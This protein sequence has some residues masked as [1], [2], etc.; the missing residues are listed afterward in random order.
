MPVV[1]QRDL[2][3][4]QNRELS[5]LKFNE[6]VLA[7]A[8][9][10][11]LPLM[12]RLRFVSIFTSNLDEFFMVRVGSLIDMD[13]LTPEEKENKS[14][15]TPKQQVSAI[16]T[17]VVPLIQRRDDIYRT[18][19]NELDN[20]GVTEASYD[21][22]TAAQKVYVQDYYKENIRPLLSPQVIDRSHPFPHLKNKALYAAALLTLSGKTQ[23]KQAGGKQVAAGKQ[24][25]GKQ[26]AVSKHESTGKQSAVLGIVD[27]PPSLPRVIM[28]PG[29]GVR[30]IRTEVVIAA[31]MKKIFKIYDVGEQA[32]ISITRNADISLS[33]EHYDD[34]NPDLLNYMRSLLKKRDR[35]APVRLE[36]EGKAPRLAKRL[37]EFLKLD[38][39]RV[40]SCECP[41][42]IDYVDHIERTPRALFNAPH[43]PVYPDYL[44]AD[45]SVWE[46]IVQ[47]DVLLFYP[48]QSMQP[49]LDLLRQS[50]KDPNVVSIKITIYRL[51]RNSA[52]AKALCA[53]AEN[54]K[55]VTV[56]M[57]LRARFDEQNNIDWSMELEEAGCR[58]IYGP[59]NLKCHAKL[60]LI[61][62]RERGGLGYIAQIG[63][64]NYNEKTSTLYTDFCMMTADPVITRDAVNFFENM[65]IGNSAGE[66]EK[67]LVAPFAMKNRIMEMIDGQ[68][69]RG[70]E[71][72]IRV[73]AN[74][75]TD[76]ELI[77]KLSEA[78]CAGVKVDLVIRGI[79]CLT[80][81]VPGKTENITVT[82][83]VGRFLEH[84]RIYAFGE[85]P[86]M[87]LYL[88][89]ADFMTRNQDR[90][91]EVGAPV[92]SPELKQF[93]EEYLR[94]LLADNTR[95]WRQDAEG[96][97]TRLRP[98]GAE[99][100]DVQAWYLTHP[101]EFERSVQPRT[102]L[103]D[104][105]R[106]A[107]ETV[108]RRI[109]NRK[110][111]A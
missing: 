65:L 89:S 16:C 74:S 106:R 44:N 57:E 59:E 81:G 92:R 45:Q 41:L 34:E 11:S 91:V 111:S 2:S 20:A 70:S 63:T 51:A 39:E 53:A 93:L 14:G 80:P 109:G 83:V 13:M 38:A 100:I 24:S 86:E 75:V 87:K 66:Y 79:C 49:F 104:R 54:G 17:A 50:T 69:A 10:P 31:H 27:V 73:K 62:R 42:V 19:M 26:A 103:K 78:S 40:F 94:L 9:D 95:A 28:L 22:L 6:R 105:V 30:Y 76:R 37:C 68:I 32:V 15:M 99:P 29:G 108:N 36:L 61:T 58:I 23:G 33:E 72:R 96:I 3:F 102:K 48:Y 88:S 1:K 43:A 52:I 84:S 64:G 35:L 60:C 4:T 107:V 97:Y 85:E 25:G 55:E 71:G 8:M 56:L 47:R 77:D 110:G 82:S 46:Q 67:L 101:I 18:L 5:W 7:Q 98:D 90:R 21:T 12:E